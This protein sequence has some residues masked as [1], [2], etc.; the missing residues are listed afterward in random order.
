MKVA[1][2]VIVC[3]IVVSIIITVGLAL[4]NQSKN[5]TEI[6]TFVT[7]GFTLIA[8]VFYAYDT[9]RMAKIQED[10]WKKELIPILHYN[11]RRRDLQGHSWW[12]ELINPSKYIIEARINLNLKVHGDAVIYS[13]AYDGTNRW[14]VYPG[15]TSSGWFSIDQILNKKGL[16]FSRMEE[17]RKDTNVTEQLTMD[18]EYTYECKETGQS[19]KNPPRHHYFDFQEKVW[20]P[21]LTEAE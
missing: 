9:H 19:R 21:Y 17:E 20:V 18:L 12:F 7:L 16:T 5:Y 4:S 14:I 2:I 13:S 3:V 10:R 11:M 1:P 8:L 15:Q 6:A